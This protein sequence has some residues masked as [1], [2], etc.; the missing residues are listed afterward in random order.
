MTVAELIASLAAFPADAEVIV[1]KVD[2][3]PLSGVRSQMYVARTTWSGEL[4][5]DD[6]AEP[7]VGVRAVVLEPVD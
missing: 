6:D 5:H 1:D 2:P 7:G 3:S 4:V